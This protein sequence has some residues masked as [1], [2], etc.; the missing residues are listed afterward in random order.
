VRSSPLGAVHLMTGSVAG[1]RMGTISV[2][3]EA[4]MRDDRP[5][6]GTEPPAPRPKPCPLARHPQLASAA[7]QKLRME[8]PPHQSGAWLAREF[9][10]DK[11][12][13]V[14]H[15][16]IYKSLI[17]QARRAL[18]KQLTAHLRRG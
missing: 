5:A 8:W 18:K 16:T 4:D 12:M 9:G 14:S 1:L 17:L 11:S 10:D 3:P 13:R 2:I 15:E 6:A 7:A